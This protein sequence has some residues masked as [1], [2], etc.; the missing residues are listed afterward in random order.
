MYDQMQHG[1][2]HRGN[3]KVKSKKRTSKSERGQFLMETQD[4]KSLWQAHFQKHIDALLVGHM[5]DYGN[6]LLALPDHHVKR[7][8]N[9]FFGRLMQGEKL[10]TE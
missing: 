8:E 9:G 3:L 1:I 2:L 6:F 7:D 10:K 4:P 5:D